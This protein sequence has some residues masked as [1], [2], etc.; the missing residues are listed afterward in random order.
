[1]QN[2]IH[3]YI[4]DQGRKQHLQNFE[5]YKCSVLDLGSSGGDLFDRIVLS[6]VFRALKKSDLR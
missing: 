6:E 4:K 5:S 2:N 1:M 3:V